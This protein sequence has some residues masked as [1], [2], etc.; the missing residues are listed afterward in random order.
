MMRKHISMV[1]LLLCVTK[2]AY[3]NDSHMYPD[4]YFVSD[5]ISGFH[6]LLGAPPKLI[7]ENF[8]KST[9]SELIFE[10]SSGA[11]QEWKDYYPN[12]LEI[13]WDTYD[14]M[15]RGIVFKSDRYVTSKGISIGSNKEDVLSA[16]GVPC[17]TIHKDGREI[18]LYV[19]D[20]S[21]EITY[22]GEYLQ[23]RIA[24]VD[25]IVESVRIEV[26]SHV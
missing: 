7:S 9:E 20:S 14:L 10:D 19:N 6:F 8:C 5:T 16:Y 17:N 1:L 11:Y 18:L 21:K 22:D 23:I 4:F 26:A 15:I 25:G 24:L 13:I 3:A 12:E 2:F